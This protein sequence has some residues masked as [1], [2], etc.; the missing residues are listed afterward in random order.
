VTRGL[1][2]RAVTRVLLAA[3]LAVALAAILAGPVSARSPEEVQALVER[4]AA[5]VRAYGLV[6]ALADFNRPD[7]GFVDGELYIFC[8]DAD[9][10]QIANGANPNV[11]GRNLF[12]VR[13]ADGNLPSL[14]AYRLGQAKGQGWVQY[15]WPNLLEGRVQRKVSY[16]IR[17]DDRTVCGSGYYESDRP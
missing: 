15:R 5:H 2:A 9:G 17:I 13:D 6:Q 8:L 11:V 14:E 10:I 12:A 4:A 16:V 7:G 3:A 1:L